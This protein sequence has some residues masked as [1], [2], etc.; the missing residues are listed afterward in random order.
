MASSFRLPTGSFRHP[1]DF[2]RPAA[3][4][5]LPVNLLVSGHVSGV[6]DPSAT[7]WQSGV[8]PA[9]GGDRC[10]YFRVPQ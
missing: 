9:P 5:R 7:F 3:G 10:D 6:P 1:A 4:A 8:A 2:R